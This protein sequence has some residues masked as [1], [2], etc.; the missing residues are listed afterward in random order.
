MLLLKKAVLKFLTV[1]ILPFL[2]SHLLED[3][4]LE[5]QAY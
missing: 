2:K 1:Q 4:M 5:N 3:P